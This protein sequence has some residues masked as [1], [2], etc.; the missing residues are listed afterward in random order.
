MPHRKS[1][2]KRDHPR[3][4]GGTLSA[5]IDFPLW[6]GPSPRG[7]GN[8]NHK[9]AARIGSGTIPA[10]AGEPIILHEPPHIKQDHPRVG[11]GTRETPLPIRSSAGPSPRGRGNRDLFPSA[12]LGKGTIPAW[13]GEPPVRSKLSRNTRDHPRVGGGTYHHSAAN[14]APEGPSPRGRG[15]LCYSH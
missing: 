6:K 2:L 13:A 12:C 14:L 11:G 10:W 1:L 7:R 4:G 9:R 3:V 15:N 5:E 8:L